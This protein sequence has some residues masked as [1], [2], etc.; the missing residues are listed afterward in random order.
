MVN[1]GHGAIFSCIFSQF[2][3][4]QSFGC[5]LLLSFHQ[6]QIAHN[7]GQPGNTKLSLPQELLPFLAEHVPMPESVIED[8]IH[9]EA[10]ADIAPERRLYSS[11]AVLLLG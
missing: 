7:I 9:E 10:A 1:P 2:A 11:R 5:R 8:V 4:L 6:D 3:K